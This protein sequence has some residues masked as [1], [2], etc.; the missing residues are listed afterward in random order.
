[1]LIWITRLILHLLRLDK[2]SNERVSEEEIR[3]LVSESAEQGVIDPDER[4]MVNRV[5]R[6]GDRSVDSLMTPRPRI[7]WL[8]VTT[9]LRTI[10][11]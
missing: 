5:L 3:L 4:N 9:P 1:M 7:V 8:D 2:A 10:W 6:L 11:R